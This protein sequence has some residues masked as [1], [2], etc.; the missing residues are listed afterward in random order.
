MTANVIRRNRYRTHV[1]TAGLE[2]APQAQQ[3]TRTQFE[4]DLSNVLK[5]QSDHNVV[6]KAIVWLGEED[7]RQLF[8][9]QKEVC[10]NSESNI[11]DQ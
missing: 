7:P 6:Q 9:A 11:V 1:G 5:S 4:S 3:I 8:L 2:E 10:E